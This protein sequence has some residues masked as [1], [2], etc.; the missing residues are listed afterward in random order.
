MIEKH[1]EPCGKDAFGIALE[2]GYSLIAEGVIPKED[3]FLKPSDTSEQPYP[4]EVLQATGNDYSKYPVYARVRGG[5]DKD[6]C[7]LQF[8]EMVDPKIV[9]S[10]Y[11][12]ILLAC[13]A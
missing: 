8:S 9:D 10:I 13:R 5:M 6:K 11:N 2:I 4:W 7:N 3:L 12:K 1:L